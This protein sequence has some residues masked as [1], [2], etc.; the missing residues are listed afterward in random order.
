LDGFCKPLN[1]DYFYA[2]RG[3]VVR[4]SLRAGINRRAASENAA[5]T[6]LKPTVMSVCFS[7]YAQWEGNAERN[8]SFL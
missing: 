4:R 3:S 6:A 1:S 8:L 2:G 7:A 5:L